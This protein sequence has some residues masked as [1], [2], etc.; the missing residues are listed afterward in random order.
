MNPILALFNNEPALIEPSKQAVFESCVEATAEFVAMLKEK[1]EQISTPVAGNFWF[2]D[3][4]WRSDYRP[5]NVANGV[6]SIPVTGVLLNKFP[7]ATAW[8][9]GYEYVYQAMKR[10][11]EDDDV[12]G[13]ALLIDSPGGM[14]SG[15]FDLVDRM[16]AMR[17]KKPVH[18]FANDSAYSAAYSIASAADKI[19]V[20]RSGGVGSIG[21]VTL[22]VDYSAALADSGIKV[23]FIYAGKH[24]VDGNSYEPLP[25]DVRKKIQGRIDALYSD[26]VSIVARNR[27]LDEKA[28]RATE[29]DTFTASEA[30]KNGLADDAGTFEDAFAAFA[31][32]V[33]SNEEDKAMAENPKAQITEEMLATQTEAAHAAGF[34]EGET[35]GYAA[36]MTRFNAIIGSEE[37][38][39]RPTAALNAALKTTMKAE[40]ATAFLATL[41]EEAKPE[42]KPQGAGAPKGMFEDAMGKSQNPNVGADGGGNESQSKTEER[43]ALVRS[44][45]L[46]GFKSKE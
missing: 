17:G 27:S 30:I 34:K 21:V 44:F 11:M 12:K 1:G 46:P 24:K 2:S 18:A 38:K 42:A 45:G 29:A 13:I 6:L 41:P 39:T 36:A 37:A 43:S 22:H 35:A 3:D 33:N 10:G 25:E 15:N 9:T 32:N 5:Y 23:T 19:S 26:F 20:S 4:D 14:V 8:G 16:F 7:W 28:V 31:A 40:E